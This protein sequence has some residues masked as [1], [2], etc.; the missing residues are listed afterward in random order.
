AEYGVG[1]GHGRIEC[2]LDSPTQA[3]AA[4]GATAAGAAAGQ[5]MGDRA[6]RDGDDRAGKGRDAAA[7][8]NNAL[9]TR[10]AGAGEG[11][12]PGQCTVGD[13]QGGE[14]GVD[15]TP[16]DTRADVGVLKW[17]GAW[18]QGAADYLVASEGRTEQGHGPPYKDVDGAAD[19]A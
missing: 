1:D 12:I 18:G 17:D 15:A 6:V 7:T 13:R 8:A 5:I 9:A 19:G 4:W 14:K 16:I 2:D 10:T 11:L 3:G